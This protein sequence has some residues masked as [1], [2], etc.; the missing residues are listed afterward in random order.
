MPFVAIRLLKL[1]GR[2]FL[3][4]G[5][6]TYD[7]DPGSGIWLVPVGALLMLYGVGR[8]AWDLTK[9][10]GEATSRRRKR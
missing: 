10:S 7:G 2:N 6:F 9:V 4:G 5:F 1:L 8:T 3:L